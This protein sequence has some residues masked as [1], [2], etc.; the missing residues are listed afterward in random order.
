MVKQS[1]GKPGKKDGEKF[2]G[3]VGGKVH[4]FFSLS[5]PLTLA[6]QHWKEEI[7]EE[8]MLSTRGR[9]KVGLL[10]LLLLL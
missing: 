5:F 6:S 3:A 4:T 10:L 2:A 1:P 9:G 7:E 8:G